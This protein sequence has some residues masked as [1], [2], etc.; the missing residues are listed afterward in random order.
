MS[1]WELY[2]V[3]C[4]AKFNPNIQQNIN[5]I[6]ALICIILLNLTINMMYF[7]NSV[8][9]PDSKIRKNLIKNILHNGSLTVDSELFKYYP[10][11]ISK[12][13]GKCYTN[14]LPG[15]SILAIP[16]YFIASMFNSPDT[17][18]LLF[19]LFTGSLCLIIFYSIS[20]IL[21]D[22]KKAVLLSIIFLS[23]PF[24]GYY[25]KTFFTEPFIL[26]AHLYMF[27]YLNYRKHQRSQ[28][29]ILN[30]LIFAGIII[31]YPFIISI[32]IFHIMDYV[33][34]KRN[35]LWVL[36][37]SACGMLVLLWYK[38][39]RFGFTDLNP[40]HSPAG[41]IWNY[42]EYFSTGL[43]GLL[44]SPGRGLIVLSPVLL[45]GVLPLL[46]NWRKFLFPILVF[47]SYLFFYAGWIMWY[48][49][50]GFGPRF[51]VPVYPFLIFGL[52][53]LLNMNKKIISIILLIFFALSIFV[54]IQSLRIDSFKNFFTFQK[55]M[56]KQARNN[57]IPIQKVNET[58][59]D[60]IIWNYQYSPYFLFP[61]LKTSFMFFRD[62]FQKKDSLIMKWLFS[63]S[64]LISICC[65]FYLFWYLRYD[66][67][68]ENR[69]KNIDIPSSI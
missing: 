42:F 2:G 43:P 64:L 34:N 65:I 31:K 48:G 10:D 11:Q 66:Q 63:I 56:I 7:N 12:F 14:Y 51:L 28:I 8:I 50:V 30:F 41:Y 26:L 60:Q 58:I 33:L 47:V 46:K 59:Y 17:G 35:F 18:L 38:Y 37:G 52:G 23:T 68:E 36:P 69:S 57:S 9:S 16:F 13:N 6:I 24:L 54:Q 21:F 4:V 49:G 67:G 62:I 1:I 3:N 39:I 29:I 15:L 40:E 53:Y 25:Q 22:T 5:S 45:L 20:E 19:N 61:K 27:L 44:C 55:I 32:F